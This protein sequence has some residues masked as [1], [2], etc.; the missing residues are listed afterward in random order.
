MARFAGAMVNRVT[1]RQLTCNED[2]QECSVVC[3]RL[4]CERNDAD[5]T[6]EMTS[7]SCTRKP[8][9]LN[10]PLLHLPS[11]RKTPCFRRRSRPQTDANGK[12][13]ILVG[14]VSQS[15]VRASDQSGG[16]QSRVRSNF[17]KNC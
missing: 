16:S 3:R 17:G 2:N 14:F 7:S 15:R 9:Y 6:G 1:Q 5:V 4:R 11:R 13:S 10:E 12:A 8:L